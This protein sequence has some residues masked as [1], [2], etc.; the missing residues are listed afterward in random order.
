MASR[1]V[2]RDHLARGVEFAAQAC[3]TSENM[4]GA[5]RVP[6]VGKNDCRSKISRTTRSWSAVRP[7]AVI[8]SAVGKVDDHM[9]MRS[10]RLVKRTP[11]TIPIRIS[12]LLN[13]CAAERSTTENVCSLGLRV[14]VRQARK[15]NELMLINSVDGE[16]RTAARVVYC[17][18][19][20]DGRFALGLEF[21]EELTNWPQ[22]SVGLGD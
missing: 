19:T 3:E 22:N 9:P 6:W 21:H 8:P 2:G 12:S 18:R 13:P 7:G 16:L 14:L 11:L 15:P 5:I 10:G 1:N 4:E 17:E 20:G